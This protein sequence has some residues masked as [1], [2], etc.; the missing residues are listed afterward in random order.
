MPYK[1]TSELPKSIKDNLP[2]E[3][4]EI[5]RKVFNNAWKQYADPENRRGDVSRE[6]VANKV[7]WAAVKRKYKKQGDS[8]IKKE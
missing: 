5:F 7:A 3:A 6:V 1:K 2:K 8:W 4:Q